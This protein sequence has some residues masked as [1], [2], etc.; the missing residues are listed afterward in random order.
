[1]QIRAIFTVFGLIAT[2][3]FADAQDVE[4]QFFLQPLHAPIDYTLVDAEIEA[5]IERLGLERAP[6]DSIQALRD[7]FDRMIFPVRASAGADVFLPQF[8][9]NFV[10]LDPAGPGSLRDWSCGTRTY[11]LNSGYDHAG[12]DISAG[13]FPAHGMNQRWVDIVAASPG[14]IIARNHDADDRNCGGLGSSS[15]ANYVSILQDD[16]LTAYYWHMARDSLTDQEVGD[17][18]EAGDFLGRVGSSGISTAPHLH[19]ELRHPDIPGFVVD[20]YAGACG[21][22]TPLWRHQHDYLD[23]AITGI[24]THN[25]TPAIPASFC[26]PEYPR[27]RTDFSP[28]DT[29]YLGVYVRDQGIGAASTV[30]LQDP[31]GAVMYN[32]DFDAATAFSASTS[33]QTS[34]ALPA[35]AATGRWTIRATFQGDVR[36]RA[37]YVGGDPAAGARLAAAVLPASRS[38]QAGNPATAFATVLNPS[39]VTASGCWV[40]PATPFSGAFEYRETNPATNAITGD[41]N[42][43]FDIP[44]GGSRSFV[45]AFT[46]GAGNLADSYDLLL[47]YKCDNSDAANMISGVN[48]ILLSFGPTPVPDIVAIAITPSGDGI[49]RVADENSAAAFATAVANVGSAGTLTVRPAAR[50]SASSMRLRICETDPGTGAC[51]AAAA[52]TL[53]RAFAANESASFAIF[54][55]A[56]GEVVSFAPASTRIQLIAEDAGG[57][58]RGS[59][60]VAVRTN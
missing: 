38:V 35:N 33:F 15:A 32:R 36:E 12:T 29:V 10:D 45:L 43:L 27:F 34:Y 46:P 54:A 26:Q 22:S 47:R 17:R 2:S 18:V 53:S 8:I 44:A 57:V 41:V 56:Q 4:D 25:F 48:S 13:P 23:P 49:L 1:M 19:F 40:S 55:R 60:S 30:E 9:G 21:E 31:S 20:P 3:A 28:G 50:G 42:A 39:G 59:T 5:N 16:G 51:L 37:F 52:D 24:F 14:V 58:I 11:D 6:V 7:D